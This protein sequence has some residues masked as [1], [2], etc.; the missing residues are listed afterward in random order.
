M[1]CPRQKWSFANLLKNKVSMLWR[2]VLMKTTTT[3]WMR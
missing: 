2:V 1:S 3:G